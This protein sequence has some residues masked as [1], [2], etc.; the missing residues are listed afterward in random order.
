MV[1]MATKTPQRISLR[2]YPVGFGDCFLLGFHYAGGDDRF[3]L[4]DFG[5][6][7]LTKKRMPRSGAF[8]DYMKKVAD[9]I[10]TR[11]GRKNGKGGQIHAVIATHR[12]A[13]HINGFATK[14][15]PEA[16]EASG[17]VIRSLEPRFVVQPWTEDPALDPKALAPAE[18]AEIGGARGF[19]ALLAGM[20]S[21]AAGIVEEA[22]RLGAKRLTPP[23]A[24]EEIATSPTE[25]PATGRARKVAFVRQIRFLGE[26]NIANRSA[27]QNLIAMGKT[28]GAKAL[29]LYADAKA[30]LDLPGVKMH[31]LGPPTL[32]QS[33]AIR[34]MRS[35]DDVEF[36]MLLGA[37]GTK[38]TASAG[39]PFPSRDCV[40]GARV[41]D[42]ARWLRDHVR[43]ARAE[44]LLGIV[45]TLDQ[46]MNNTSLILVFE[47]GG[48]R[49]L[50][51]GD[52]Q[53]ENWQ[54]ALA[55]PEYRKLL[56][57]T[58]L[59]KVGHHGSRNAT[60]K[61]GLWDHFAKRSAKKDVAD[62]MW[63]IVSTMPGK[64]GTTE[65][66]KVPRKT[67]VDTLK[68]DTNFRTTQDFERAEPDWR[69]F[70]ID[71][72]TGRVTEV[73]KPRSSAK[74]PRKPRQ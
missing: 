69:D 66:T 17:D 20:Q 16:P 63:S 8:L 29:Y 39:K 64:H 40:D 51:P 48:A 65:A 33:D 27:V 61:A 50:F 2:V 32:K 59:Y 55:N 35:A 72:K 45:R 13:D 12:H 38:F 23:G 11:C 57:G 70:D 42:H 30:N 37:T 52:A 24:G 22:T 3:V 5:S 6:T 28:K 74:Q 67:L 1:A 4:V 18:A 36:W 56:V 7:E 19:T 10:A 21:A 43:S 68:N 26:D 58:T 15:K 46:Q 34:K 71:P 31:V 73:E 41:P 62:R 60:P 44:T 49:L 25:T 54:Y 14:A 53:I 47:V 9:D